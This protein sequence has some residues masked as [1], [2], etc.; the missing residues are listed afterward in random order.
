MLR[1]V[2]GGSDPINRSELQ[3]LF[4]SFFCKTCLEHTSPRAPYFPPGVKGVP[5]RGIDTYDIICFKCNPEQLLFQSFF[6]KKVSGAYFTSRPPFP[7]WG[8][9]G[10]LGGIDADDMICL[11]FDLEQLSFLSFFC[12][13]SLEHISRHVLFFSPGVKGGLRGAST[14]MT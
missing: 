3:L 5:R 4:Q 8:E 11:K 6:C 14:M 12:K 13:T 10:T 2:S 9:G 1:G 7:P